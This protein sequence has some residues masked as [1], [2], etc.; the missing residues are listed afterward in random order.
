[1]SMDGSQENH[2]CIRVVGG[3]VY[4]RVRTKNKAE[5]GAKPKAEVKPGTNIYTGHD[6]SHG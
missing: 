1:M 6:K 3:Q 2:V 5:K 4:I